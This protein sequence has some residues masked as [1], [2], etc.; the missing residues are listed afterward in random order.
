MP[1]ADGNKLTNTYSIKGNYDKNGKF[2]GFSIIFSRVAGK[3]FGLLAG[4]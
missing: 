1:F 3:S 2:T 4:G